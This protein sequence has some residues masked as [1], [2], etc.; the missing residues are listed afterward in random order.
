MQFDLCGDV[1]LAERNQINGATDRD[2]PARL[3]TC[4]D[5]H[6]RRRVGRRR[7][8]G[9]ELCLCPVRQTSPTGDSSV[10][11]RVGTTRH[12]FDRPIRALGTYVDGGCNRTR[13]TAGWTLAGSTLSACV[14]LRLGGVDTI[15]HVITKLEL[16]G[17]QE[18]A[19]YTVAHLDRTKF[20]QDG[21]PY[22]E[23]PLGRRSE[24]HT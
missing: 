20:R 1:P 5:P 8:Q 11:G 2:G 18:V 24:E 16:G 7:R 9:S 12:L 3:R 10:V 4:G 17:A 14:G 6:T 15:C 23:R 21:Q 22:R 19:L 13:K